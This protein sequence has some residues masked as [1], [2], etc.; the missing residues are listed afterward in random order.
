MLPSNLPAPEDV[1][2]QLVQTVIERWSGRVRELMSREWQEIV[3]EQPWLYVEAMQYLLDSVLVELGVAKPA[4]V[5]FSFMN[6]IT[7]DGDCE[8]LVVWNDDLDVTHID[9]YDVVH[10]CVVTRM[11]DF[12][13][14][15]MLDFLTIEEVRVG[16]IK[17]WIWQMS[18][19]VE[20]MPR[21]LQ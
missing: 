18:A 14:P 4:A 17:K 9:P 8:V 7:F 12:P 1:P 6:S 21:G 11:V 15:G 13:W 19:A 2:D 5:S 20:T 16:A 10:D 3:D